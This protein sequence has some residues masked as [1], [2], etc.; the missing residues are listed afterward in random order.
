MGSCGQVFK[1]ID[2]CNNKE[3]AVKMIKAKKG[4]TM[5]AQT[6]IKLLIEMQERNRLTFDSSS[7]EHNIHIG[8]CIHSGFVYTIH[9]LSHI[10]Y[11]STHTNTYSSASLE[12]IHA[13]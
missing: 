4:A 6:E 11:L 3:V 10:L 2:T 9:L 7:K 13:Q 8:M 5:R 1:A 12:Y